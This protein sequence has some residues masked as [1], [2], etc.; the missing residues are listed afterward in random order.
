M[1]N[2][3]GTNLSGLT[4]SNLGR[5]LI[6]LALIMTSCGHGEYERVLDQAESLIVSVPDKAYGLLKEIDPSQLAEGSELQ[7]RYALLYTRG[8]YKNSDDATS[9]SLITLAID[10]YEEHGGMEQKFYAYL[11]QGIVRYQLGNFSD[12][13]VSLY[14]ALANAEHESSHYHKGLLYTYLALVNGAQNCQDEERYAKLAHHEYEVGGLEQY[15]ASALTI[16]AVAKMHTE[17]YDSCRLLFDASI[18]E[19]LRLQN[20]F[21]LQEAISGMAQYAILVDSMAL[22]EQLYIDLAA[23]PSYVM[24]VQD[25]G[26]FAIVYANRNLPDSARSCLSKAQQMCQTLN[27]TIGFYTK[28]YWTNLYLD[29]PDKAAQWKDSLV[30]YQERLLGETLQNKSLSS[31]NDYKDWQLSLSERDSLHKTLWIVALVLCMACILM[32]FFAFYRKKQTQMLLQEQKIRNL[33]LELRQNAEENTSNL[34]QLRNETMITE[35]RSMALKQDVPHVDWSAIDALFSQRLPH[36][37]KALRELTPL[38]D[39]EWRVCQLLKL[40]FSPSQIA[41][42][43]SRSPEAISSIRRRLYVKVFQK[44]GSPADWDAFI[45]SL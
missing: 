27:D 41:Q 21:V 24:T 35:L 22:A 29:D 39:I 25:L 3:F 7:A 33:Q 4:L 23:D 32:A 11:Y 40:G 2:M 37:G 19:A 45:E 26:N 12:A 15:A 44:K 13:T 16:W 31:L 17:D 30:R 1:K 8:Q 38:S 5:Y 6:C 14:R 36:F 34:A 10:Y 43:A 20:D 42:L 18:H 28:A 9:D